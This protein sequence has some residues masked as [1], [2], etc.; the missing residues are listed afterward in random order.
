[1]LSSTN[2]LIKNIKYSI[3]NQINSS[4][5]QTEHQTRIIKKVNGITFIG[6][7]SCGI[8]TLLTASQRKDGQLLIVI[9]IATAFICLITHILLLTHRPKIATILLSTALYILIT[10]AITPYGF[11]RTSIITLGLAIPLVLL[12]QIWGRAGVLAAL[13]FTLLSIATVVLLVAQGAGAW[14]TPEGSPIAPIAATVSILTIIGVI[15]AST[16]REIMDLTSSLRESNARLQR[17]V[18]EIERQAAEAERRSLALELHDGIGHHLHALRLHASVLRRAL[19]DQGYTDASIAGALGVILDESHGAQREISRMANL[20]SSQ[21]CPADEQPL[22]QLLAQLVRL[23]QLGGVAARLEVLGQPC[24]P[25]ALERQMLY[26]IAQEATT[27]I[28]RHSHATEASLTLD[29]RDPQ[30]LRLTSQDNG[31]GLA[32]GRPRADGDG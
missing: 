19:E 29:Y 12:G 28:W 32:P 15:I 11:S 2:N 16:H 9:A 8:M 13:L 30:R 18:Q 22:E 3:G 25:G 21:P 1:M 7:V 26:R 24:P 31:V 27:N 10:V 23:C 14:A 6:A 4:Y 17:A 20:A 5:L